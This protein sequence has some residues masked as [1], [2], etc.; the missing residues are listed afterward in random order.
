M[1]VIACALLAALGLAQSSRPVFDQFEVATIKPTPPDW[2]GGRYFRM[3][4]PN[5][6]VARNFTFRLLLGAAYNVNPKAISGGPVWIDS[7]HYDISAVT[8]GKV[9]PTPEEEMTMLQKLL[10]DRFALTVH[11]EP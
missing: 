6:F 9:R 1:R 10:V 8:P 11:R 4:S 5:R 2:A 3:E 7:D